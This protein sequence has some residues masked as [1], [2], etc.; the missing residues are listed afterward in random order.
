MTQ[1]L[2]SEIVVGIV[3]ALGRLAHSKHFLTQPQRFFVA[4][5]LRDVADE[6]DGGEGERLRRAQGAWCA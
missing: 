2:R 6:I 3:G 4:E 1:G 5:Q